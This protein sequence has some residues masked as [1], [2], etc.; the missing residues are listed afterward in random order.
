M[1]IFQQGLT[2][3]HPLHSLL[4]PSSIAVVGASPDIGKIRGR[5]LAYV[6]KSA[7]SGDVFPINPSYAEIDGLRCFPSIAAVGRSVDVALIAIPAEQVL[8]E[9]ERCAAAGT[10]FAVIITSG[11]AE[12][13]DGSAEVQARIGEIARRTGMRVIGPNAEGFYN[14]VGGIIASFS[15]TLEHAREPLP[16][17]GTRRVAVVAQSG[18]VGFA[19][20]SHGR[21]LGFAFSHIITSGNEADL[22]LSDYLDYLV[23]DP[24]TSVIFLYLETIRDPDGFVRAARRARAQGKQIVAIKIGQSA[25]GQRATLSHTASVAGWHVAY[26]A[27]FRDLGILQPLDLDEALAAVALLLAGRRPPGPR[28]AVVTVSGGAGALA[29]DAAERS[30]LLLP[31][32]SAPTRAAIEGMLPSYGSAVNPIDITATGVRT[33]ALLRSIALLSRSGEVDAIIIVHSLGG[34]HINLDLAELARVVADSPIPVCLYSYVQPSEIW[35]M[36]MIE[37]GVPMVTNL[38]G[39]TSAIAR[40]AG[41]RAE[42]VAADAPAPVPEVATAQLHG[43][44]SVLCEYEAKA[45]LKLCGIDIP[46]EVLARDAEEAAAAAEGIGFPVVMKIQSPDIPHKSEAGGVK[47]GIG[48]KEAARAAYA[49]ILAN[50]RAY[51]PDGMIDGMLIQASAP[52]GPEIIIGMLQD[53]TFG[54]MMMV[55]FGGVAVELFKD[56]AYRPAPVTPDGAR[57]M[58]MALKSAPLLSGFRGRT[59]LD[60]EGL[61]RL[62]ARISEIAVAWREDV[63]ELELNPVIM[64]ADGSGFTIADALLVRKEQPEVGPPALA[65]QSR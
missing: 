3:V 18:G 41:L 63:R 38:P 2:H 8:D 40:L 21:R 4:W 58:L 22:T 59:P 1:G 6:R 64:H 20:F 34:T 52:A 30:G 28:V 49:T 51:A 56:V 14:A 48:S 7:F 32:P 29:A 37:T 44:R 24:D 46:R 43:G 62:I 39:L 26:D 36:A 9:L 35:R 31:L 42:P 27:M 5:L 50:A 47:L 45:L 12:G 57:E 55:G 60:L 13:G 16:V 33:G 23:D 17:L 10:K 15:P 11:F 61:C 53:D 25:A 19:L 54:P 65:E